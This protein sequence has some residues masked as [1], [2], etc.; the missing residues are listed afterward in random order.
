M[1]HTHEKFLYYT[2]RECGCVINVVVLE[3]QYYVVDSFLNLIVN[4]IEINCTGI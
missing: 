4:K 2:Y 1:P 3:M